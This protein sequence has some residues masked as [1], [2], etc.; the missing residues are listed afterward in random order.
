MFNPL[1]VGEIE[2]IVE[3]QLKEAAERLAARGIKVAF[4]AAVRKLIAER[5][6]DPEFGARPIRRLVQKMIL[7]ELADRIIK[8][9]VKHGSKVK[10]NLEGRSLVFSN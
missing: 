6:F 2:R 8:G 3:I 7:D 1:G 4:N 10:V 5:G 9:E